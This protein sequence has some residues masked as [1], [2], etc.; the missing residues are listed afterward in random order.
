MTDHVAPEPLP[1]LYLVVT[2]D[3][4]DPELT[5]VREAGLQ[6]A[7]QDGARVVLY[8]ASSE[9]LLTDPYPVGAWSPEDDATSPSSDLDPETLEGLGR[10][11]LAEQL[12]EAR[13]R[14]LDVT[15]YLAEGMGANAVAEAVERFSPQVLVLPEAASHPSLLDKLRGRSLDRL[16]DQV[17]IEV[18]LIGADGKVVP[19]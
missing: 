14:G 17:D 15:A 7:E 8:D 2:D 10:G 19:D 16:E 12:V 4:K 13:G 18:R 9:S 1:P 5:A 6:M 11:Y 3:G